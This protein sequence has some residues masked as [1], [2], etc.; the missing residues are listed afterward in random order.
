MKETATVEQL[1]F[2]YGKWHLYT[3]GDVFLGMQSSLFKP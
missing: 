1:H 2:D 3:C